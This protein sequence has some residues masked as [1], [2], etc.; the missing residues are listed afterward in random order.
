M[1]CINII[2]KCVILGAGWYGM[3]VGLLFKIVGI[4]FVVLEKGGEIF[5]GSSSKNQHRLHQGFHYPRSAQTRSEC[6]RGY[7]LFMKLFGFMVKDVDNNYYVIEKNS[8]ISYED[9]VKLYLNEGYKFEEIEG[10]D[11]V[12]MEK[13]D[14]IIKCDEKMIDWCVAKYYF[15]MMIGDYVIVNYDVSKLVCGNEIMYDGVAYDYLIDCT[16]GQTFDLECKC[17]YESVVTFVYE[18][19]WNMGFTLMDGPYFSMYPC[20]NGYTLTD[21]EFGPLIKSGEFEDVRICCDNVEDVRIN[22]ENKVKEYIYDF[23]GKFVYKYHYVSY[24]CKFIGEGD[25]RSVRYFKNGN[26]LSFI[27]GKIT[28]IFKMMEI[29]IDE[30]NLGLYLEG[31]DMNLVCDKI[32]E[33]N[34]IL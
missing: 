27:G 7:E 2:M 25:D 29:L 30:L 31:I 4:D 19:D 14:G 16:Y 26:I 11:G 13:I 23:D 1:K 3:M 20:I 9:Y 10:I 24:K 32:V 5:G 12:N 22:I 6:V 21:V 17:I 34:A 15:S 8:L 28:G 18:S 33:L